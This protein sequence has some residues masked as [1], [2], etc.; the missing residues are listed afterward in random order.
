[1]QPNSTEKADK[2]AFYASLALFDR[3]EPAVRARALPADTDVDAVI[4]AAF[5]K[6]LGNPSRLPF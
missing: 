6:A 3:D 4:E 5:E 1:M 2:D